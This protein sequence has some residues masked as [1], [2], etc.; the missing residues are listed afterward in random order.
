MIFAAVHLIFVFVIF[1][2]E[3]K[4]S[5]PLSSTSSRNLVMTL[6]KLHF[7]LERY[8]PYNH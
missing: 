3:T 5:S 2:F 7:Q 4:R 8:I 6:N 1:L